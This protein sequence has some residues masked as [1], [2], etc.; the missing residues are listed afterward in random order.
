MCDLIMKKLKEIESEF[1]FVH[2]L[3]ERSEISPS[4]E[5]KKI[6]LTYFRMYCTHY[7]S[8]CILLQN[9]HF[10][11]GILIVRSMLEIFVKSHYLEFIAKKEGGNVNDYLDG[12]IKYPNFFKMTEVLDDF[13]KKNDPES[14]GHFSQYTKNELASYEKF[15]YFSHGH[16]EFVKYFYEHGEIGYS[17]EQISDVIETTR[18]M[19]KALSILLFGAQ[20]KHNGLALVLKRFG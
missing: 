16:G 3:Q 19:F 12:K 14:K 17:T 15:S 8:F 6:N 1:E 11:S 18:G 2:Q 20:E 9:A 10:S 4:D 7:E 13:M 5:Y